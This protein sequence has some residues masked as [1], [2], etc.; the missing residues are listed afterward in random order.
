MLDF[1]RTC[2]NDNDSLH[3]HTL[4]DSGN[5]ISPTMA[6]SQS[7]QCFG[8]KKTGK[9]FILKILLRTKWVNGMTDLGKKI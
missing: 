7:V 5:A 1:A 8:K 9:R 6:S 2:D 3:E 4:I